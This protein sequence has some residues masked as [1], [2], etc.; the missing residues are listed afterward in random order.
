M[1]IKFNRKMITTG[2]IAFL[3]I[4]ASICFYYLIFRSEAFSAKI[5]AFFSILSPVIYGI[6]IAYLLTP[7]VNYIERRFLTPLFLKKAPEI[8]VKKKKYMRVISVIIS[9]LLI[10][11]L[12]YAF[13]SIIV[14]E[15]SR[16]IIAISY[17]FPYY[18]RNLTQFSNKLLQDNPTLNNLFIQFVD[19]Y[20]GEFSNFLNKTIIPQMQEILKHISLSLL[21]F[22]KTLWNVVIGA[23]ISVYVLFNKE[24]FAGQAKKIA[25]A[26]L[27]TDHANI[28]IKDIRFTSQTFIGFLSGKIIDSTIIGI[29]CFI[30]LSILKMPYAIL[31]S[32]I[33]GVTNVIPFFGPY[34]GAIPSALLILL[35]NPL[36]C[37]YF[38]IFIIILQQLDGNVIGP[39]ILGQSTGLS[40]F[41]VIFSITIFGGLWGVPGMIVGVPLWAV[42]YALV[43]RS[44]GRKLKN[45]GLPTETQKY[46]NVEKIKGKEFIMLDPDT[47]KK[48]KKKLKQVNNDLDVHKPINE[49]VEEIEQE[50]W[51]ESTSMKSE[52]HENTE[53]IKEED[54]EK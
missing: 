19:D 4:A 47:T 38:I 7:I 52:I 14:P 12:L 22:L 3:V 23:I 11:L 53:E 34:L 6:I 49:I 18:I 9:L 20:S 17:Q 44:I 26:L 45:K 24:L 16:S 2:I 40:G 54:P 10:I 39:K 27:N 15:V 1:K 30:G 5:S 36:K 51:L 8:N 31:V 21:S 29:L 28:F 35:V 43:K 32:V 33:V 41:W 25:Y 50:S 46:L 42:I 13:I 48:S 37:L